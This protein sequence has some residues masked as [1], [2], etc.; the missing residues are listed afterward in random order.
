MS[1][2]LFSLLLVISFSS[3]SAQ[4]F[5]PNRCE[6]KCG[7]QI[8]PF[9]FHLSSSCGPPIVAFKLSCRSNSTLYLTLGPTDFRIISFL[10]SG[11]LLLDYTQNSSSSSSSSSLS[12]SCK[13]WYASL[14]QPTL[15]FKNPFFSVTSN[16][17]LRLYD[18]EDSSLCRTACN[19]AVTSNECNNGNKRT[20]FGCC[21][22]LSDSSVWKPRNGFSVFADFGCRGFSSWVVNQS[23]AVRGIEMEWAVPKR[24]G[25][26][27]DCADGAVLVNA[28][29]VKGGMR[30]ACGAGFV[31][32][33]YAQGSGCFKAC[34]PDPEAGGISDCCSGK[35]CS[36]KAIV[37]AGLIVSAVFLVVAIA[38]CFVLRQPI[39]ESKF[40]MDPSCIPKI[41]SKACSTR[42]FTY[43]E[44]NEAI[45]G[46]EEQKN[47]GNY[48][49]EETVHFGT[50]DDGS[51]VAVQK[52]N[53]EMREKL[54]QLL[55]RMQLLSRIA[56][57]NIARIIGFCFESNNSLLIVHEHLSNGSVEEYLRGDRG[58]GLSW[59][60]RVN[61]GI[62]IA[63]A[64]AYLQCLGSNPIYL[65]DLKTSEIL[66]GL[67]SEAKIIGYKLVI[68]SLVNNSN[69]SDTVYNFGC[70]LVELITGSKHNEQVIE[71][72]L[73]KVKERKFHEL[74]DPFLVSSKQLRVVYEEVEKM[75]DLV[76]KCLTRKNN[77]NEG[78]CMV[79]VAKEIMSI[80][81]DP[82]GSC[83]SRIEISLEETFSNSS[84]LQMISMSPDSLCV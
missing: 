57:K 42:Q 10:S 24:Y 6:E 56:H 74:L 15:F 7:D 71:M 3:S 41:L 79:R 83:S 23:V 50:L 38:F 62:E 11:S 70:L 16:N 68:S 60:S 78:F 53:Y 80:V 22:P 44:L 34:S 20:D 52:V 55:Q 19:T 81:R 14:T 1:S 27:V 5:F 64:L 61:I 33:G 73:T 8:I 28:T 46:F 29:A 9:P 51:I 69:D 32:D 66:L 48:I 67:N 31:G 4:P 21:Y 72:V 59:Y 36:K 30:C 76:F 84:L 35:F 26:P 47:L 12:G 39:K 40:G 13:S 25:V 18:C 58:N 49:E 54:D 37:I 65:H 63:N 82:M 43:E 17:I 2:T 75:G 45:K 77:E